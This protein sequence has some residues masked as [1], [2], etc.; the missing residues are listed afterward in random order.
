MKK[1][2]CILAAGLV[3]AAATGAQAD[4]VAS[5]SMDDL[6]V[7]G[8]K[9]K[10]SNTWAANFEAAGVVASD[11]AVS[12]NYGAQVGMKDEVLG[13]GFADGEITWSV[14]LT[15]SAYQ[16]IT[17]VMVNAFHG[18]P[19]DPPVINFALS[20]S[21]DDGATWNEI[22]MAEDVGPGPIVNSFDVP[23]S[24]T[25]DVVDFS[26]T[27]D[28]ATAWR[29]QGIGNIGTTGND[30]EITAVVPEP[31]TMGILGLGIIGLIKRRR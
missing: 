30:I 6:T 28:S 4:L 7:E 21:L 22:A 27:W 25:G 8:Q 31:T 5:Y 12:G 20:Y 16:E 10:S 29:G 17:Q 11:A 1:L 26:L 13:G 14:D 18:D 19:T 3:L 15:G 2:S 9:E 24:I 23:V